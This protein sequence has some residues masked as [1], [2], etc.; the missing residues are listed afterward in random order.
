MYKRA[1]DL[2]NTNLLMKC[3]ITK[4]KKKNHIAPV[5]IRL[6]WLP[7]LPTHFFFNLPL[8]FLHLPYSCDI[9]NP[10]PLSYPFSQLHRLFSVSNSLSAYFCTHITPFSILISSVCYQLHSR[11]LLF[12]FIIVIY[13]HRGYF[14][15]FLLLLSSILCCKAP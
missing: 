8:Q 14:F 9:L 13:I 5:L 7:P 15:M 2:S 4:T 11:L 6:H 12:N 10:C 1:L 3:C